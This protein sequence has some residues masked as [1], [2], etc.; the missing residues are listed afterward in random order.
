LTFFLCLVGQH[1]SKGDIT[2]AFDAL[3]GG[4]EL[5]VD[6]DSA[7]IVFLDADRFEVQPFGI[8]TTAYCHQNHIRFELKRIRA[9]E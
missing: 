1:G 9:Y 4:V 5:V 2:D 8:W 6:D 7:L 3:D